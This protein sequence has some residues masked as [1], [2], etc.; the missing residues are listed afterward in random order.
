M[1]KKKKRIP[2]I[3]PHFGKLVEISRLDLSN[4]IF[5]FY[6]SRGEEII[7]ASITVGD[8]Y[9]RESGKT[10]ILNQ[11]IT[12]N[13]QINLNPNANLGN[14]DWLFAIDTN[15][16]KYKDF[17]ISISCSNYFKLK[18]EEPGL[19]KGNVKQ[20]WTAR[21]AM[22]PAFIFRNPTVNPE[23][24]GW[25]DLINRIINSPEFKDAL[26]VGIIVDSELAALS[27]YNRQ[28]QPI[29]GDKYLP[30]NFKLIYASSDVGQEYPHNKLIRICDNTANKIWDYLLKQP[31]IINSIQ[32]LDNLYMDGSTTLSSTLVHNLSGYPKATAL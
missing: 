17:T 32:D 31:E 27:Q 14:F 20:G 6:N 29:I 9:E 28:E 16:R 2:I 25:R 5:R 18:L 8:S 1:N 11:I 4:G 26:K 21:V 19:F 30:N 15:T 13:N 23:V 10:K 3:S 12:D 7:P 22:H 24:I